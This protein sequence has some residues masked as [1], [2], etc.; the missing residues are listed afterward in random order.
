MFDFLFGEKKKKRKKLSE[1]EKQV[2]LER[3]NYRCA[4]CGKRLKPGVIHFDHKK[5]L[6]LGGE[7]D[8]SNIQALCPECHHIKTKRDRHKIVKAKKESSGFSLEI[9]IPSLTSS[10][11]SSRRKKESSFDLGIDIP[12]LT[13]SKRGKS[14][15]KS[16]SSRKKKSSSSFDLGINVPSLWGDSSSSKRKRKKKSDD[17]WR[18]W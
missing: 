8:I 7:D 16:E 4:M 12:S 6:A 18:I 17:F 11:R 2:I 15:K 3:Q 13:S 9:E 1:W 10:R 5:P 14:S